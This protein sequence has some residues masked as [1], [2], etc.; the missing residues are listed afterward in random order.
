MQA[1]VAPNAEFIGK[2]LRTID[3]RRRYGAIVIGFWR[4]GEFLREELA[5]IPLRAGDVLVLQGN[6]EALA[7]V[8]RLPAFLLLA[9]FHNEPRLRHKAPLVAL[10]SLGTIL[11]TVLDLVAIDIAM[12]SGAAAMVLTGCLTLGQA[13]RAIDKRIYV[14]IA[15]AIPL[16]LAMQQTGTADVLAGLLRHL[17]EDWPRLLVLLALYAVV[18]LLTQIMSDAA[19]VA[20][21]APVAV[22]LAQALGAPPTAYVV[23]VAMAAVT[24]CLTPTGHHGN[25][26]VYGPGRY[27]FADF[28]QVGTPFTVLVA[29]VVV[30]LAAAL[31]GV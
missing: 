1:V 5:E 28:V 20:L 13:Y 7:R 8:E 11:V 16:G 27:R 26:L 18:G 24:A 12:L 22:A 19:T 4:Q 17:V 23:T 2:S 30:L 14:F 31:W 3:F 10:I 9:P 15:G 21:F 6:A 29:L 25:L